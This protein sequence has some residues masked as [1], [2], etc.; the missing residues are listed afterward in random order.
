MLQSTGVME[1]EKKYCVVRYDDGVYACVL[2]KNVKS[3]NGQYSAKWRNG[4][5][6]NVK[7]V[8]SGNKEECESFIVQ[9]NCNVAKE[10]ECSTGK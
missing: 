5:Y 9:K 6:Y 1:I 3:A 2:T 4:S 7:L 8:T 10:I